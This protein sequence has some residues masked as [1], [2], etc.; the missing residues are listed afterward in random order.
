MLMPR[1]VRTLENKLKKWNSEESEKLTIL[2]GLKGLVIVRYLDPQLRIVWEN[3]DRSQPRGLHH[4]A[5]KGY[6]Y[7]IIRG[8]TKPCSSGCTPIKALESGEMREKEMRLDDGRIFFERSCP[9]RDNS[10]AIRGVVFIGLN[11]TKHKHTEQELAEQEAEVKR[12]SRQLA[13]TNTALRVLLKQQEEDKREFKERIVANLRQLVFPYIS[14]LK[15]MR[16]DEKQMSYLQMVETH[17]QDIVSP[18]LRQVV[19][20]YPNMT[21][22]EIQVATLIREGKSNKDIAELMNLSVKTVET[23]RQ[24]LRKKLGL[25]NKKTNLRTYL[26]SLENV[27]EDGKAGEYWPDTYCHCCPE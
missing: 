2:Q 13:E 20:Q 24:N 11:I 22:K 16:L 10:G 21:R 15:R 4:P 19:S 7:E 9:V 3:T 18:F 8:L 12:K 27:P 17:L 23:H 6:C 1:E 14:Q 25:Q 5:S 26:L